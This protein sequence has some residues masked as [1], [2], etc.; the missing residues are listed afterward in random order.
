[1][2]E[3]HR[4][5]G[6]API[7]LI[8]A[9]DIMIMTSVASVAGLFAISSTGSPVAFPPYSPWFLAFALVL[10]GAGIETIRRRH[11]RFAVVVPMAMA[12]LNLGYVIGNGKAGA[13]PSVAIFVLVALLIGS[14]RFEFDQ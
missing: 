8:V 13:W 12:L 14:R 10:A 11:F 2:T 4:S 6:R 5:R 3:S 9:G 1:M 7:D